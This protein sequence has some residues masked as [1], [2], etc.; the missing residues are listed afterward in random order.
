MRI[1]PPAYPPLDAFLGGPTVHIWIM[2]CDLSWYG[3]AKKGNLID[4]I[5]R[6]YDLLKVK[7]AEGD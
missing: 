1:D 6:S 2:L 5:I 4:Y 3:I 7:I